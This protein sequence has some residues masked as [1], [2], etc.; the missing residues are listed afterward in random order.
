[1]S[2]SLC[3]SSGGFDKYDPDIKTLEVSL[4]LSRSLALRGFFVLC[5]TSSVS[6]IPA[7]T[8]FSAFRFDFI[9]ADVCASIALF[10][11]LGPGLGDRGFP[12]IIIGLF[13]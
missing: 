1:M 4:R 5:S 13:G 11:L 3:V 10:D 12:W 7:S 6:V 2:S 9:V 8:F